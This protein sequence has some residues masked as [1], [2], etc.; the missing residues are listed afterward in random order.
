VHMRHIVSRVHMAQHVVDESLLHTCMSHVTHM[1]GTTHTLEGEGSGFSYICIY[2][3]IY[4][5]ARASCQHLN[6]SHHTH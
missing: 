2:T 6:A 4:M 3:Y 5:K 1:K